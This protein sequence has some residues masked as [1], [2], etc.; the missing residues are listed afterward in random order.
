MQNKV[1]PNT[2]GKSNGRDET[3]HETNRDR[4]RKGD[5]RTVVKASDIR[6]W[7]KKQNEVKSNTSAK[8]SG[9]DETS[10]DTYRGFSQKGDTRTGVKAEERKDGKKRREMAG[11]KFIEKEE[12]QSS[13]KEETETN[14]REVR[15]IHKK[16]AESRERGLKR[17]VRDIHRGNPNEVIATNLLNL[18]KGDFRSLSKKNYLNDKIVDDYM[19]LIQKRNKYVEELPDV[20][21][22]TVFLYK[23]LQAQGLE[24]GMRQTQSWFKEDQ[25]K[26]DLIIFPVHE[27]QHW[28]LVVVDIKRKSVD[29]YDSIR[30]SRKSSPAP[31]V[32]KTFME[33]Y[34]RWK[35]QEVQFST[36]RKEVPVQTNGV[37][38][39][40]FTCQYAESVARGAFIEFTQ[41]DIDHI[42]VVMMEE[43]VEGRI[44]TERERK[45][46]VAMA[47]KEPKKERKGKER[48]TPKATEKIEKNGKSD[49]GRREKK[50]RAERGKCD[51]VCLFGW[52]LNV[53][54]NY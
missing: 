12:G 5:T 9:K 53:L 45:L 22:V 10:H 8:S 6:C 4:S 11:Q 48:R 31:R 13:I 51:F 18:T 15:E 27:G 44:F 17:V 14:L 7:F 26:K 52:F 35:G 21:T 19:S 32:L 1:G 20:Y 36:K 41:K 16:Q 37:D 38:C 3:S 40:V 50:E 43:L 47:E 25:R 24:E 49:L 39:G 33:T 2:K 42:R 30:G 29:Y 54:V 28:S 23:M 34:Y 46:N